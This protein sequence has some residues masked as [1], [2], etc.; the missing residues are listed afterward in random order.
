MGGEGETFLQS[1]LFL[2]HRAAPLLL[3][4]VTPPSPHHYT[5]YTL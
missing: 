3:L 4:L 5:V 2:H 1:P